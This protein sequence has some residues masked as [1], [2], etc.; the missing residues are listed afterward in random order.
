MMAIYSNNLTLCQNI[1]EKLP[2]RDLC[3]AVIKK[4][5][6]LCHEYAIKA[7][8]HADINIAEPL[9]VENLCLAWVRNDK[10]LCYSLNNI[11]WFEEIVDYA[12]NCLQYF[13][14]LE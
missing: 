5:E 4:D 3:V 11:P 13:Y 2:D 10:N 7:S 14:F 9:E 1:D 8:S 12:Y 6:N